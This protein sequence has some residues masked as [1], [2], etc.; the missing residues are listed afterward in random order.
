MSVD[1]FKKG[2][3]GHFAKGNIPEAIEAY[4]SAIECCNIN[5]TEKSESSPL[6][7]A[8][9][10]SN[11]SMCYLKLHD[12]S[13][14][15]DSDID[16]DT[17]SHMTL[18]K[19]IQDTTK[20][21]EI[22]SKCPDDKTF[23]Q[24]KSLLR[25]KLLY[26]RSKARTSLIMMLHPQETNSNA[27]TT[28]LTQSKQSDVF[29][30]CTT[31]LSNG[32]RIQPLEMLQQAKIDLQDLISMTTINKGSN[33]ASMNDIQSLLRTISNEVTRHVQLA[34]GTS[35]L[36]RAIVQL[37]GKDQD[38]YLK[39]AL[40]FIYS[41]L[42]DDLE[43]SCKELLSIQGGI[44]TILSV[45]GGKYSNESDADIQTYTFSERSI[46]F[47]IL[48]QACLN[49]EF[50]KE[51][52]K[53]TTGQRGD[54]LA[55]LNVE[56]KQVLSLINTDEFDKSMEDLVVAYMNFLLSWIILCNIQ[57][58]RLEPKSSEWLS[59]SNMVD[60]SEIV[61]FWN[62]A[63]QSVSINIK[64]MALNVLSAWIEQTPISILNALLLKHDNDI[65]H[66]NQTVLL[67]ED[68][69]RKMKP[70]EIS[71]YRKQQY[72]RKVSQQERSR[73]IAT[74]FCRLG[75]LRTLLLVSVA[76][77]DRGWKMD[78]I[79]NLGRVIKC[80][81]EDGKKVEESNAIHILGSCL[82]WDGTSRIAKDELTIEEIYDEI[83]EKD[84]DRISEEIKGCMTRG[85]LAISIL[86][87]SGDLGKWALLTGW[88][89]GLSKTE[90][91]NLASSELHEAMFIASELA[92]AASSAEES[93]PW[94]MHCVSTYTESWKSLLTCDD[95][96]VRSGAASTVAKLGLADKSLSSDEGEL[97][98][99]LEVAAG[100]LGGDDECANS[101]IKN[102][103]ETSLTRQ[104]I[105]NYSGSPVER[106]I[107]LL[108]Y[109]STRTL[110][111]EEIAHGTSLCSSSSQSI[112]EKLVELSGKN[113]KSTHVFALSNIFASIA[114]SVEILQ[115]EAFA[116]KE[117][118]L[119]DY[120][121][122]QSIGKSEE[123]LKEMES[124]KEKDD[125]EAVSLRIRKMVKKNVPQALIN[126]LD[127]SSSE[128][129]FGQI[130]IALTRMA[131]EQSVRGFMIQQG[132]LSA[133][134]EI[135]RDST[136]SD[137]EKTSIRQVHHCIAKLLVTTNP[138]LLTV[139]QRMGS[140][141]PLIQLVKDNESSD[142]QKFEALMSLTNLGSIDNE[143][144]NRIVSERGIAVF[145]YAMFSNHEMVR[146]A[147]TEAM[148]NLASHPDMLDHIR[149][150]ETMKV[151]VAFASD[152]E[153][154]LECARASIGC[155]AMVTQDNDIA[156][157]LSSSC[158][159]E[160]ML[161]NHLESG[162]LELI[163]RA[164]VVIMNLTLHGGKC[165]E[166]VIKTG[167]R[168]FC[169]AYVESYHDGKKS[170]DLNMTQSEQQLLNV[171]VNLAKEI[172][173][174]DND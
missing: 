83:K 60:N 44:I 77:K 75:G 40:H 19:V 133:C 63:I 41:S 37:Q 13:T 107:E 126:L 129:A 47:H 142:L 105:D 109:L 130:A 35:P 32:R 162:Q 99:I 165:R 15:N 57:Q 115:E 52:F 30:R 127:T 152:F 120:D 159:A 148:C 122:Y 113:L 116:D 16:P 18:E 119:E 21:L 28:L 29:S 51:L 45:A 11:R 141:R 24:Q 168:A 54:L 118:T 139:S 66:P 48:A 157:V 160:S 140:I 151:W 50:T 150:P 78:S 106:G 169:E 101:D 158:N 12:I 68:A 33:A 27:S 7:H 108:S 88:S 155:L 56:M 20:A 87:V 14:K 17:T 153:D 98:S 121:K 102:R 69:L 79:A 136:H 147:A 42:M 174:H 95:R 94:I 161:K 164:L 62:E 46:A 135:T 73:T 10:L 171:T 67:E 23:L 96:G 144:K 131:G 34:G 80:L 84:Q 114:V 74:E 36:A 123:E 64:A 143:T 170:K 71:A 43:S 1:A 146:Q 166:K 124:Q 110:V 70:R 22:L 61:S 89:N 138:S 132:C 91:S 92:S 9:L 103:P 38:H 167:T 53:S 5:D 85:F 111:K 31:S 49:D 8:T 81:F 58:D 3:N 128:N 97:F 82:G 145:S 104:D 26:R 149:K 55:Q 90:W 6:M 2:G 100:L 86:H 59:Y 117:I 156:E 93:R 76:S 137:T 4:S 72:Q 134:I 154:N 65:N 125:P 39:D 163:H 172:I 173:T 112:L 25:S